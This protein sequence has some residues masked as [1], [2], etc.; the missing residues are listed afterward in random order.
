VA[1]SPGPGPLAIVHRITIWT[2]LCGALAYLAWEVSRLA[3]GWDGAGALRTVLALVATVG[4]AVYL[5]SLRGLAARLTPK[6]G[7]TSGS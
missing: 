5:R 4:I 7:R 6:S 3:A 2:A 1:P